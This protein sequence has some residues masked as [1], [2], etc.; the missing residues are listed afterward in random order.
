MGETNLSIIAVVGDQMKSHQGI[1]GKMFST[2][3]RNN[4]NIRAIAQGASE[5]NI[6]AIIAESD[7]T[8]ALNCLHERFFETETKQINL[9]ISGVGNVGKSLIN[10]IEQQKKYIKTNLKIKLKVI[11][12][13]NSKKMTLEKDGID[14]KDWDS[15]LKNGEKSDPIGFFEATKALNLRNSIFIDITANDLVASNYAQYL[16]VKKLAAIHENICVVGDD[17]QSI[18]AFRG[19]NIQNILNGMR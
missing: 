18:Y 10:Q 1:S 5:R 17:A 16:I 19:A 7:V 8:K 13:S 15:I 9:F 3:G 2:L 6:S 11:G 12:L 14:L 4:V